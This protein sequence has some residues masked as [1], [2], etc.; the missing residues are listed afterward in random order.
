MRILLVQDAEWRKK[1][2]H[3]QHHL[4]ELLSLRGH[5]IVVVG[6]DQLWRNEKG[7][8]IS[9]KETAYNVSRFYKGSDIT[10]ISRVVVSRTP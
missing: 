4:M 3:H 8:L 1:G 6:F 10:F 5:K 2:R 9:S 7:G